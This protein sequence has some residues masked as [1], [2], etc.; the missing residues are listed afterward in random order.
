MLLVFKAT[1]LDWR[2]REVLLSDW[3]LPARTGGT[4][5]GTEERQQQSLHSPVDP[6]STRKGA[7][8]PSAMCPQ[9]AAQPPRPRKGTPLLAS[10]QSDH[11]HH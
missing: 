10:E 6:E 8:S 9:G 1:R 5:R 3:W 2:Q 7:A 4:Y 11:G